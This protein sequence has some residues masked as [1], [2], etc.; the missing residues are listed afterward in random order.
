MKLIIIMILLFVFSSC[1]NEKKDNLKAK[2]DIE[3]LYTYKN[4][5][6]SIPNRHLNERFLNNGNLYLFFTNDFK[7]DTIRIRKNNELFTQKVITTERS[8]GLAEMIEIKNIKEI[9]NVAISLNNGKEAIFEI[10][11][12]NQIEIIFEENI[13][14]VKFLGN[15]P[16]FD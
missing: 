3:I 7:N 4:R 6:F 11:E 12:T 9:K 13:L 14:K 1:T 2:Y 16:Y 5:D 8:T 10:S 15:V